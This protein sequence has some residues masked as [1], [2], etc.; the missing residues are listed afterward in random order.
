MTVAHFFSQNWHG[1]RVWTLFLC[2]AI[3]PGSTIALHW[4]LNRR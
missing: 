3:F 4:W 2:P 1:V